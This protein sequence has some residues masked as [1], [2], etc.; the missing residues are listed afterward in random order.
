VEPILI[1]W[2]TVFSALCWPICFWMMRR[3]S[4]QQNSLLRELRE[5]GKRIEKLSKEEHDLIEELHPAVEEI[6]EG[7]KNTSD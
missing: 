2:L 7:I 3:I 1:F 6:K 5:Q 4:T